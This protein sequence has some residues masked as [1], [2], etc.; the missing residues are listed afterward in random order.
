[1]S[2]AS[3]RARE[4]AARAPTSSRPGRRWRE[5]RRAV[6]SA[7]LPLVA[8][9]VLATLARSW[10][11]EVVGRE[12]YDATLA[13]RGRLIALWHG[14]MIVPL[15]AHRG[16]DLDVLVSPSD[17][18]ALVVPLLRRFG[19]GVI[20]GSSNR[21]PER[22]LREMVRRLHAGRTIVVTPDGPRGPRHTVNTGPAWMARGTGFPILPLGCACDRAWHLR[23]WDRFTVPKLGAR[24]AIV[25]G[26][27]LEVPRSADGEGLAAASDEL[28]SRLLAAEE[29]GFRHLS[30]E[31]DWTTTER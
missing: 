17:D 10:S 26:E 8:P 5:A 30:C 9:T 31:P 24:V 13:R 11:L 4:H 14:R 21:R 3:S 22:A 19:Y 16:A 7:V 1:M 2:E 27:P 29:D 20:R 28:R 12:H 6:A 23:S 25:Y 15:P 18:G